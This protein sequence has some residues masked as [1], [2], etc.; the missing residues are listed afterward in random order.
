MLKDWKYYGAWRRGSNKVRTCCMRLIVDGGSR[1]NVDAPQNGSQEEDLPLFVEDD[2][3]DFDVDEILGGQNANEPAAENGEREKEVTAGEG[4]SNT[5]DEF[6][7][8]MDAMMDMDDL[9]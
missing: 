4:Q 2:M 9:F 3:S 7:D 6:E 1:T 8:E 5:R